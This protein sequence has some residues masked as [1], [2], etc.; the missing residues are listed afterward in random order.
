MAIG[1]KMS[2]A[3]NPDNAVN[4]TWRNADILQFASGVDD[5]STQASIDNRVTQIWAGL[6]RDLTP[7]GGTYM[8]EADVYGVDFQKSFYGANY[9]RLLSIKKKYDPQGLFYATTAVGSEAWTRQDNG[10]LCKR[11]GI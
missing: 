6:L 7:N 3:G 9:D 1:A 10:R 5:N 2:V 11:P 8:N 4:P